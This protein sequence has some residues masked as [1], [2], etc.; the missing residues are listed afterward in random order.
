MQD[1]NKQIIHK[2]LYA[3]LAVLMVTTFYLIF[4]VGNPNSLLRH[5]I[6][7][8]SYDLLVTV[9]CSV[10]IGVIVIVLSRKKEDRPLKYLLD[11]NKEHIR[12]LREKGKSNYFI[13]ED[14]LKAVGVKNGLFYRIAFWRVLRYL[15][16]ME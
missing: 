2:A 12:S 11:M 14:F 8:P 15:S 9:L 3:V 10:G 7:D 4:N 5:I 1:S 16:K 13:A 6:E